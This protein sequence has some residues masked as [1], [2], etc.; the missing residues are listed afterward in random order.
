[1]WFLRRRRRPPEDLEPF[2][3]TDLSRS[4]SLEIVT[5]D[6]PLLEYENRRVLDWARVEMSTIDRWQTLKLRGEK[7]E[8]QFLVKLRHRGFMTE[9]HLDIVLHGTLRTRMVMR[10]RSD[11][12]LKKLWLSRAYVH[13]DLGHACF[14]GAE[15]PRAFEGQL[16]FA[17]FKHGERELVGESRRS[18]V[19]GRERNGRVQLDLHDGHG[20]SL[21]WKAHPDGEGRDYRVRWLRGD[22]MIAETVESVFRMRGAT[23]AGCASLMMGQ[24]CDTDDI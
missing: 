10:N 22:E 24:Y 5:T 2:A 4:G 6:S 3:S 23:A 1:M 18:F 8:H 20:Y 16:W 11:L 7:P 17:T 15:L 13:G 19:Y 21:D 12:K 9:A 14:R